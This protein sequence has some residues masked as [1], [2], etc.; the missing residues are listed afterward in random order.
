MTTHLT[1]GIN[2]D[3][4]SSIETPILNSRYILVETTA[5]PNNIASSSN[6]YLKSN[7]SELIYTIIQQR[8]NEILTLNQI[9]K[10]TKHIRRNHWT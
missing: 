2:P 8:I 5:F 10:F 7:F 4:V 1:N 3:N 9:I 6:R